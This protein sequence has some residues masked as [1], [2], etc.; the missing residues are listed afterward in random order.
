VLALPLQRRRVE[1]PC[2]RLRLG[3]PCRRPRLGER[4]LAAAQGRRGAG[5]LPREFVCPLLAALQLAAHLFGIGAQC[6]QQ[7]HTILNVYF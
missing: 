5:L 3:R 4:R 6:M 1:G 7:Q 2:R